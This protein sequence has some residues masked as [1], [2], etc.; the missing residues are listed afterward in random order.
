ML[1]F[2]SVESDLLFDAHH[3]WHPYTSLSE[4]LPTYPVVSA[5]GTQ[6]TLAGGKQL[7]DGMAS[8]WSAIHGYNHPRLNKALTDQASQM[9]HVMF[10]GISHPPAVHLARKLLS[11]A[12]EPLDAVFFA[13]S[14]SIAVEVAIKMALQF[15][16]SRG[17][18]QK[19]RLL[20]IRQ[21]YHG[22]TFA[23]MAVCDP[24]NDM[25][26][27]FQGVLPQ[28]FFAPAP[29]LTPNDEWDNS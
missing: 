2:Q 4:P 27:L 29:E 24:V 13:D 5:A 17:L 20:T 1:T 3:I 22:D 28:H 14:G 21:G 10:G 23:T 6:L 11:M 16:A 25:H 19:S 15:Q 18:S 26:G 8:W 12:P 7:T 9:S